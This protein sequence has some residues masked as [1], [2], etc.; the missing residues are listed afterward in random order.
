MGLI[1]GMFIGNRGTL[2]LGRVGLWI[3]FCLSIYFWLFCPIDTF[4]PSLEN[5]LWFFIVYN[6][7]SKVFGQYIATR[8]NATSNGQ[9]I[10]KRVSDGK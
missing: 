8:H 10:F 2:A 4:P 1:F 3:T 7:G 6:F 9:F 5:T